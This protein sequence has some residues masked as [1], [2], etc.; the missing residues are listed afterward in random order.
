MISVQLVDP[1]KSLGGDV[2][3]CL[4]ATSRQSQEDLCLG[5]LDEGA[6][7]ARWKCEDQ[8]LDNQDEYLCGSTPHFTNFALL[9]NGAGGGDP[10][11]SND[12]SLITGSWL[13]D[14]MLIMSCVLFVLLIAACI[15][16]VSNIFRPFQ[17]LLL[18]REGARVRRTRNKSRSVRTAGEGL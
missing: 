1:S 8:C 12:P 7:P 13:G 5:Y 17:T 10:C 18:G 3:I 2:E 16:I 9:L 11:A 15:I 14:V 6:R 4:R